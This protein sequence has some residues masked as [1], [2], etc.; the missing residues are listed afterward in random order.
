MNAEEWQKRILKGPLFGN[1][2]EANSKEQGEDCPLTTEGPTKQ[3][4]ASLSPSV[5]NRQPLTENFPIEKRKNPRF[6]VRLPLDY[7]ETPGIFEAGL[8]ADMSEGG[9]CIH[10]VHQIQIG[11]NLRIR[12]YLLKEELG[13]DNI[14]GTGKIIWRTLHVESGW[15]G[16]KYGLYIMQMAPEDRERLERYLTVLQEE[17]SSYSGEGVFDDYEAYIFDLRNAKS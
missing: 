16:Y 3:D 4:N 1:E 11:A 10:S 14:E 17:K 2:T 13:F 6:R 15:K 5:K 12:V 9:L 7:S 8:V